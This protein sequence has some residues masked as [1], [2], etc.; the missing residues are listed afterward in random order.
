MQELPQPTRGIGP[1]PGTGLHRGNSGSD[2]GDPGPRGTAPPL[3][4]HSGLHAVPRAQ[5]GQ[6]LPV[7]ECQFSRTP[8]CPLLWPWHGSMRPGSCARFP[9]E[10]DSL[11][12]L[13]GQTPTSPLGPVA[14]CPALALTSP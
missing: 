10:R 12:P 7:R 4:L 11:L 5:A 8:A 1:G 2:H 14:S 13:P 9:V 3:P 6:E